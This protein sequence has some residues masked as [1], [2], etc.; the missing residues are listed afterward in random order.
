MA[1]NLKKFNTMADYSAATLNYPNVSWV[2]SGDSVHYAKEAPPAPANDKVMMYFEDSSTGDDVVLWN[3]GT[4]PAEPWF[5]EVLL[6]DVE[7]NVDQC[8][9]YGGSVAG[10]SLVKYTLNNTTTIA[11]WFSGELGAGSDVPSLEILIPAQITDIQYLPDNEITALVVESSTPPTIAFEQSE[12]PIGEIYVPDASVSTYE[13]NAS[14]GSYT[15]SI[16][17]ISQYSGNLPL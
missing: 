4:S 10:G 13:S 5:T 2:V 7:I 1:N 9:D 17:P 16:L 15:G 3:C 14:W 12:K 11:D 8:A 6:N